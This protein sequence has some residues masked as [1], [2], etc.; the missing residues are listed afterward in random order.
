MNITQTEKT[1]LYDALALFQ[2]AFRTYL[3]K[4]LKDQYGDNWL[5]NFKESLLSQQV[6][7]LER[8]LQNNPE[9]E[10][11][12]DFQH[13]KSFALRNKDLIRNDF[14]NK[15]NDLP[16]WLGEIVEVRNKIAHFDEISK[17]E[18]TKAWIHLRAIARMI[19][20]NEI[21]RE[22]LDLEKIKFSQK[23]TTVKQISDNESV[24]IKSAV[25]HHPRL[26]LKIIGGNH[27]RIMNTGLHGSIWIVKRRDDYRTETTG[28]TS[29][30]MNPLIFNHFG[31][32]QSE[33]KKG[34]KAWFLQTKED[35]EKVIE[36][37]SRL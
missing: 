21:E 14:G 8:S 16:T 35:V 24:F 15:T 19:G 6:N 30:L 17:D 13:F 20:E 31:E 34:Y 27:H 18:A 36:M 5:N 25:S 23:I 7:N 2:N 33:N 4:S 37:Y 1:K 12:V 26:S 10:R 32:N 11:S 3:V 22:I 29:N 9:P 28:E